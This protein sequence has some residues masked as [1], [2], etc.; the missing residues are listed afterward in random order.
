MTS[1]ILMTLILAV[2]A[3]MAAAEP[4]DGRARDWIPTG[5]WRRF[6]E[7]ERDDRPLIL[8]R[9]LYWPP[10]IPLR[11][12]PLGRTDGRGEGYCLVGR[13]R[14][15]V[16]TFEVVWVYPESEWS[17]GKP[18]GRPS[19]LVLGESEGLFDLAHL[20]RYEFGSFLRVHGVFPKSER[21]ALEIAEFYF[22][23]EGPCGDRV[24]NSWAV[25][26]ALYDECEGGGTESAESDEQTEFVASVL[27]PSFSEIALPA[28][29]VT[30]LP[31][32]FEV[33]VVVGG[34]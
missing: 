9:E 20:P 26:V 16:G 1:M 11:L 13:S 27:V 3:P 31:G 19:G 33:E 4:I 34:D 29:Q 25:L 28:P 7:C 12:A 5:V 2:T 15:T 32:G 10:T 22:G 17:I 24:L 21:E 23:M 6:L 18:A 8:E 30:R 14:S